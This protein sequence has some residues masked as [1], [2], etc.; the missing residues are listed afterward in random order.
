MGADVPRYAALAVAGAFTAPSILISIGVDIYGSVRTISRWYAE[1]RHEAWDTLRLA[2]RDDSEV[3]RTFEA[4]GNIAAWDVLRFDMT[5]RALPTALGVVYGLTMMIGTVIGL[6]VHLVNAVPFEPLDIP[7]LIVSG[8]FW[9][10]VAILYSSDP[11]WR[12]RANTLWSLICAMRFRD[13]ATAI[14][15]AVAGGL[16]M[17][18]LHFG[19]ILVVYKSWEFVAE[20]R[21]TLTQIAWFVIAG[22]AVFPVTRWCYRRLYAWLERRALA[23]LAA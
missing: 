20:S 19:A 11:I 17:R 8:Y 6:F 10:R 16:G 18:I 21:A 3:I 22:F 9:M 4:L 7:G 12:F 13:M 23:T 5:M 14:T 15:G 2:M 1:S